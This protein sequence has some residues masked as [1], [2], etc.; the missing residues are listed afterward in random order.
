MLD[1]YYVLLSDLDRDT[2]RFP[3]FGVPKHRIVVFDGTAPE[4]TGPK[5][6]TKFGEPKKTLQTLRQAE[7]LISTM[8]YFLTL[9]VIQVSGFWCT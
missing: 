6:G 3:A 7:E 5:H 8:C 4:K 2:Y 1:F 9:T